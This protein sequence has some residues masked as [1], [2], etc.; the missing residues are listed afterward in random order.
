MS[1]AGQRGMTGKHGH[2]RRGELV[3]RVE[4]ACATC[5]A[6]RLYL[7]S[8][9]LI[10]PMKYCSRKCAGIASAAG[11]RVVV[12]CSTCGRELSVLT[13]RL[14]HRERMFCGRA[15][16]QAARRVSGAKWR[17]QAQI[18]AYMKAYNITHRARLNERSAAWMRAHRD[19]RNAAQR[20]RRGAGKASDFTA[21]D[22]AEIKRLYGF[23]CLRC[24]HPET[25]LIQLQPDHV[26]PT[27][28]GGIHHKSN[29]QPLCRTCNIWKSA[30]T[31]DYRQTSNSAQNGLT[32][33]ET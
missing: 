7:Q 22:W 21:A 5:G 11:K 32:I 2:H 12:S 13:S 23:K 26:V 29:I 27:S 8:F 20:A 15:C 1:R 18:A 16:A 30:K 24:Q 17:D 33:R 25:L 19:Q 3:A 28:R 14:V 31:I 10:H 4:I 9:L 6:V